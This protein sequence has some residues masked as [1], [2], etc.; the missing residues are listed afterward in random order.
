MKRNW[1]INGAVGGTLFVL[2][3]VVVIGILGA[4]IQ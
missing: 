4:L 3:V 1:S 2:A